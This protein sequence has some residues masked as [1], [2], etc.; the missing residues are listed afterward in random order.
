MCSWLSAA[1]EFLMRHF[2][3]TAE[4]LNAIRHERSKEFGALAMPNGKPRRK[5]VA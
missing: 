2:T 5:G 1:L 4:D 3:F